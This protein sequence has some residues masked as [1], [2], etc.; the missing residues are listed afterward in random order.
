MNSD[1]FQN[2]KV[3]YI[4]GFELPDRNAAA[5]R[6]VGIAK[7]L[8]ELQYEVLFL[9][10]LKNAD[11]KEQVSKRYF[12]FECYEYQRE[13]EFDY[14]VTAKTVLSKIKQ[15]RPN[16][17]FAYNYPAVALNKIRKYC[18]KNNIRCY[19]DATEWYQAFGENVIYRLIKNID[20]SYRMKIV[21]KRLDGVITI[22]R[23]LYEYYKDCVNSVTI[24]PTVDITEEK[25][26]LTVQK[27]EGGISFVYAGSPS[28]QKEELDLIVSAIENMPSDYNIL[29]NIVG[30]SEDQFIHIYSWKDKLSERIKFWGRVEHKKVIEIV[31]RSNWSIIIRANNLVVRAGFPTKLVESISCGTPVVSNSFSNVLDYLDETNSIVVQEISNIPKALEKACKTILRVDRN[32]FDYH[33]YINELQQLLSNRMSVR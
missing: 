9:N 14:L 20:T 6:V 32:V 33:Q 21:Q 24:P 23:F 27:I 18:I 17:I 8:R 12:G 3:L 2:N 30:V 10:S 28:A 19:A 4:G 22:S 13:S 16:I 5:Q 29:L 11:V 31:K 15:I 25:W 26:N 1:S 7:A